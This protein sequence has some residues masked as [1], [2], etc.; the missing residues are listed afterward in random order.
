MDEQTPE[1]KNIYCSPKEAKVAR[2]FGKLNY[3]AVQR[4][5]KD[6][7]TVLWHNSIAY[8]QLIAYISRTSTA[9][10]G[11]RQL[12]PGDYFVSPTIQRLCNIFDRL[13]DLLPKPKITSTGKPD[14][15]SEKKRPSTVE[16]YRHWTRLML[17][18]IFNMVEQAIPS[19][20]CEHVGELGQYL[21]G[22][23][24]NQTRLDY[25]TGHELS[26]LFFLCAL[27]RSKVLLP[28]DEPAAALMLFDRYLN[29]VRRV[30]MQFGLNPAGFQGAYSLDDYQFVSYLW[31]AAQLCYDPPFKPKELLDPEVFGQW[32]KQY[33]LAGSVAFAAESKTGTFATH[34][35]QLWSVATLS[36]WTQVYYG[37]HNM[38]LKEIICQFHM[39]RHAFFG[40]LM[41]FEPAPPARRL[42]RPQLGYLSQQRENY[43]RLSVFS[44]A[45]KREE[46]KEHEMELEQEPEPEPEQKSKLLKRSSHKVSQTALTTDLTSSNMSATSISLRYLGKNR[47]KPPVQRK[48]SYP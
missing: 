11:I 8:H 25:G 39:L 32:R 16:S 48:K 40:Q 12:Y 20:M 42:K 4:V 5:H 29:C 21:A 47:Y 37:L 24:G 22:S 19:N 43:L 34:S 38:Y 28:G 46:D 36:S 31:G 7:D 6:S 14:Q 3:G 30:Q 35:C 9:I 23:F 17:R 41:S 15:Y 10:Q 45:S 13:I 2:F 1:S 44:R 27:F 18:S 26:F 33:L